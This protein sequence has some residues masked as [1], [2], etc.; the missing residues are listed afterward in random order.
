MKLLSF[1]RFISED[2][3]NLVSESRSELEELDFLHEIGLLNSQ[4]HLR[5]I[6]QK[7]PGNN[8]YTEVDVTFTFEWDWGYNNSEEKA[9]SLLIE[10][11]V[12][13]SKENLPNDYVVLPETIVTSGWGNAE[14][15]DEDDEDDIDDY[16]GIDYGGYYTAY[17]TMWCRKENFNQEELADWAEES[18]DGVFDLVEFEI[19]K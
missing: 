16:I 19:A 1:N 5:I 12:N 9:T 6:L 3:R 15:S 13:K 8:I 17:M 2:S 4:E 11:Y 7:F 14:E 18:P 10:R